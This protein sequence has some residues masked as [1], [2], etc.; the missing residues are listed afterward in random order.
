MTKP[1]PGI[2]IPFFKADQYPAVTETTCIEVRV[3][4]HPAFLPQLAGLIAIATKA[5]NYEGNDYA[6]KLALK[7]IWLQAYNETDWGQCMNCEELTE[8]ITPLLDELKQ[9]IIQ[10]MTFNQYGTNY[11]T[12]QPLP[13]EASAQDLAP[14]A[15]PECDYDILWSQ[16]WQCVVYA[17]KII[18]DALEL[19]ESATNDVELVQVITALPVIDELGGDAIA[20]YIEVLL[21]GVADNY[22]A[23]VTEAYLQDAACTLFCLCQNDCIVNLDRLYKVYYDRMVAAFGTPAEIFTTVTDLLAYV[24]DQEIEGSLIADALNMVIWGGGILS[25]QFL[26]DVGTTALSAL[27]K[28]AVNDA[29]NDWETICDACPEFFSHRFDFEIDDQGWSPFETYAEYV[30]ETGWIEATPGIIWV[31][32]TVP[33]GGRKIN[34]V[35]FET[36]TGNQIRAQVATPDDASAGGEFHVPNALYLDYTTDVISVPAFSSPVTEIACRVAVDGLIPVT[37][38]LVALTINGEGDDPF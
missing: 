24:I 4:A 36:S 33:D 26:G 22:A 9:Q 5:F 34:S 28:L 2:K 27:L 1:V 11:P 35:R 13:E 8:C 29:S 14:S 37:G 19:A 18:T 7:K 32:I 17:D 12:G 3:P 10:E 15:N 31:W 20:A 21:E 30:E 38:T 25:N 16:C 23:Q 6:H